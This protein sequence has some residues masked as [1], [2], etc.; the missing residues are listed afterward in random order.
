MPRKFN[1]IY[2]SLVRG[3]D[4][5][6]GKLA[7]TIYKED[8]INFIAELKAEN[9]Q[10]E[11]SEKDLTQFHQISSSESAI[12]RYRLS[13]EFIL[14]QFLDNSL[15]LAIEEAT[16]EI[17]N[18]HILLLENVIEKIK[19][20]TFWSNVWQNVVASFALSAIIAL[21]IIIITFTTDGFWG[22]VG[23]FFNLEIKSKTEI[24]QSKK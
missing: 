23:K 21:F 7:Y 2:S 17:K 12:E 14:Q 22:T 6:I 1:Y 13:A 4:D 3:E 5:F 8:K 24:T 10:K 11:V 18:N 19:P 15:E 16:E 9:P 20:P